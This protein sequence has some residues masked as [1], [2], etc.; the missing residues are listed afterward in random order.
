M[1]THD[2]DFPKWN[3]IFLIYAE[4]VDGASEASD[5]DDGGPINP[6]QLEKVLKQLNI[7][8]NQNIFTIKNEVNMVDQIAAQDHTY[9][10]QL[11]YNPKS[12]QNELKRIKTLKIKNFDQKYKSIQKVFSWINKRARANKFILITWDHGSAFGIFKKSVADAQKHHIEKLLDSKFDVLN[13][14]KIDDTKSFYHIRNKQI[15]RRIDFFGGKSHKKRDT[16]KDADTSIEILSNDHLAKAITRGFPNGSVDALLMLNCDMLNLH[17]C[18]SLCN[19]VDVLIAPSG[20]IAWPGYDFTSVVNLIGKN[21]GLKIDG[22]MIGAKIIDT[23]HPYYQS[24]GF[25]EDLSRYAI[26]AVTLKDFKKKILPF[27]KFFTIEIKKFILNGDSKVLV[28]DYRTECYVVGEK[29]G[30][31]LIDLCNLLRNMSTSKIDFAI[32]SFDYLDAAFRS[33]IIESS[34][35]KKIYPGNGSSYE[36]RLNIPPTGTGIYFF[37]NII[38]INDDVVR[39]FILPDAPFSTKLLKVVPWIDFI[40]LLYS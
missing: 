19:C 9:V 18:Y 3:I 24:L 28:R 12:K 7:Y 34:I 13:E 2:E 27:L 33:M 1:T 22:K 36:D 21:Q 31:Y 11:S 35:G 37:P 25:E 26:F 8:E 10:S 15:G 16:P 29:W 14:Q 38:N 39:E 40:N 6:K 17:T 30:Y 20:A 23:L 32:N 4:L 5:S